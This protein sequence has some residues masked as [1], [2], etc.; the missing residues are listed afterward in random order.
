MGKAVEN[1]TGYGCKLSTESSAFK[2][3]LIFH[4]SDDQCV[5]WKLPS[6]D[7]L[8]VMLSRSQIYVWVLLKGTFLYL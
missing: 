2:S 5:I 8:K 3:I 4:L 7:V 6:K 1:F